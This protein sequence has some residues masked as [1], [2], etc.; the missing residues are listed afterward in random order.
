[1][2]W[3]ARTRWFIACTSAPTTES[4]SESNKFTLYS[5]THN[6]LPTYYNINFPSTSK[7]PKLSPFFSYPSRVKVLLVLAILSSGFRFQ[8]KSLP[9]DS[10]IHANN[11][12]RAILKKNWCIIYSSSLSC[13]VHVLVIQFSLILLSRLALYEFIS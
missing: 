11:D 9:H 12:F 10:E 7:S 3:N 1:M 6:F 5:H 4:Y 8:R 2:Y 13:A